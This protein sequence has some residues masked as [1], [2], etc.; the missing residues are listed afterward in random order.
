MLHAP[1]LPTQTR[2]P[3]FGLAVLIPLAVAV[4][5]QC[6]DNASAP[7]APP[8]AVGFG[9][10]EFAGSDVSA[11]IDDPQALGVN[12]LLNWSDLEPQEGV[13]DWG[14]LDAALAAAEANG[15]RVSPRVYTSAG[16]FGYAT[17][18]WVF[19]AGAELYYPDDG[20]Q[21]WQPVPTDPV[22][23][24][25]FGAFLRS[26]GERYNGHP[27]I[28]FVQTNAGMGTFGEMVWGVPDRNRPP[29]WSA[30]RQI[31]TSRYWIDAWRDAF[32]DTA[33]VLMENFVGFDILDQ[34]ARYAVDRGF[35]LQA[36][37]PYHLEESQNILAR[38][39]D[40]TKI[41]MEIEDQGCRSS[42][43]DAFDATVDLVFSAGFEIDYL[44]ICGET[45][46]I[47]P[48]R[49]AQAWNELRKPWVVTAGEQ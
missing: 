43:G 16:D 3:L 6:R 1:H 45:L 47:E 29:G 13:F 2:L 39:D 35:Y 31:D 36:N 15:K 27:A 22:F 33:L 4:A 17:P 14:A 9:I 49:V 10:M 40:R 7:D 26:F 41:I 8:G 48:E 37:D 12:V 44:T 11:G 32:P 24:E 46:E 19:D 23:T 20:A 18:D 34:V 21:V 42:V 28:E 30:K 5:M 25:K 38:Y